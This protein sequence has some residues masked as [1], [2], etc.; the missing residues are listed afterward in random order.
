[1]TVTGLDAP[2]RA[3]TSH[4]VVA[5]VVT[6]LVGFTSSFAVLLTGLTGGGRLAAAGGLGPRRPLGHDGS[7]LRASCRC[8]TGSRSRW[9]G[10]RRAP[11]CSPGPPCRPTGW[12]GAVGAFA[13]AGLLYL[14][15]GRR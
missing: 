1:M 9:R 3:G 4:A 2:A 11:P 7:R 14:L 12:A 15:T 10:R 5:G 13:F 6:A 8:D